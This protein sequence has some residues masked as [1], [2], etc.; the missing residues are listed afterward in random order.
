MV[1]RAL[2]IG[3]RY[4]QWADAPRVTLSG[5]HRDAMRIRELLLGMTA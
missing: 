1:R 4:R 2:C 3:V 5:T